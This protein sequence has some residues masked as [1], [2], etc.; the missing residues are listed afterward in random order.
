MP[1]LED[2]II[3]PAPAPA[4]LLLADATGIPQFSDDPEDV[5]YWTFRVERV[6]RKLDSLLG[7]SPFDCLE[8]LYREWMASRDAQPIFNVI[9]IVMPMEKKMKQ[10]QRKILELSG[11]G[12]EWKLS[13]SVAGRVSSVLKSLEELGL[14]ATTEDQVDLPALH[15]SK[16]LLYQTLLQSS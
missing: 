2:V 16:E 7:Q 4:W 5:R 8:S 13:E 3:I 12:D 9:V 6:A 15:R 11:A 14:Y 10:Y 1:K